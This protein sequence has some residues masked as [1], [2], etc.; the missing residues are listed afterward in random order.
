MLLYIFIIKADHGVVG[1]TI[2]ILFLMEDFSLLLSIPK[3][4]EDFM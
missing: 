2:D 3:F 4:L 1:P